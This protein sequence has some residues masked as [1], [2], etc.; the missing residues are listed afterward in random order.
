MNLDLFFQ[1][2][3]KKLSCAQKIFV[4]NEKKF[5]NKKKNFSNLYAFLSKSMFSIYPLNVEKCS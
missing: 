2:I 4:R 3:L 5:K 1:I